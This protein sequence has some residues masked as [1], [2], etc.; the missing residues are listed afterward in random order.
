MFPQGSAGVL[1]MGTGWAMGWQVL[2]SKG[3]RFCKGTVQFKVMA[4]FC[5]VKDSA[6]GLFNL[7]W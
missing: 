1:A 5:T 4:V 3:C 7:K 2:V 6:K